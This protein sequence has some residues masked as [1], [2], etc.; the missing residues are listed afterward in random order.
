MKATN[1]YVY[2]YLRAV[3]SERGEAG[4]YYYIGKGIGRR[5]YSK[6][7]SVPVPKD[8]DRIVII[9]DNLTEEEAFKL[10]IQLISEYGRIDEETGILRNRTNGGEGASGYKF[11]DEQLAR[12]HAISNTSEVRAKKS[13]VMKKYFEDPENRAKQSAE[14]KK[15]FQDPENIAKQSASSKKY[16]EDPEN[17]ARH[18]AIHSTPEARARNSAAQKK[19]FEDPENRARNSA[20]HN[21]PEYRAG[22]SAAM[23]KYF[24]DPENRAR[25]SAAQKKYYED[26]ENRAKSYCAHNTPEAKAKKSAARKKYY[27]DPENRARN[28]AAQKLAWIKRKEK[29]LNESQEKC[30]RIIF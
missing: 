13:A 21:T 11:T 17:I 12:H 27:E 25:N 14:R 3:T 9:A 1:F 30:S 24:E 18:H 8:I 16:F 2:G 6:H 23:K 10:E 29:A 5:A 4:T 7:L 28:S 15:Y 26:P 19:R 22:H 20:A